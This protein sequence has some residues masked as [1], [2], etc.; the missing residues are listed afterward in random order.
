MHFLSVFSFCLKFAEKHDR[1]LT[2]NCF[3]PLTA[4]IFIA[5]APAITIPPVGPEQFWTTNAIRGA[6]QNSSN[7][8]STAL[9]LSL[10]VSRHHWELA[11]AID[12]VKIVA[13]RQPG[14]GV[15][16]G[17]GAAAGKGCCCS[18][19]SSIRTTPCIVPDELGPVVEQRR[20]P[21]RRREM[22]WGCYTALVSSF[23]LPFQV[24]SGLGLQTCGGRNLRS[25]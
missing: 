12:F 20:W 1:F 18:S 3:S 13:P 6:D 24:S 19:S 4:A 16:G 21:G 17:G 11:G 5:P 10:S 22:R 8:G 7:F 23:S 15:V 25:T 2:G 9:S 14:G